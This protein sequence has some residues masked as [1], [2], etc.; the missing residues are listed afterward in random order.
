M[1]L[2][3]ELCG[4]D[5]ALVPREVISY[6]VALLQF[7]DILL[8]AASGGLSKMSS[9]KFISL[10]VRK[11]IAVFKS[12]RSNYMQRGGQLFSVFSEDV[13]WGKTAEITAGKM[14]VGQVSMPKIKEWEVTEEKK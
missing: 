7:M 14:E 13:T 3:F 4:P 6:L 8:K 9:K 2:A 5:Y 1:S 12:Q 10:K 11:W